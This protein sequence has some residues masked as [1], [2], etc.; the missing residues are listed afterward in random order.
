MLR[1][2]T[3]R[4]LFSLARASLL[5]LVLLLTQQLGMLHVLSHGQAHGSAATTQHAQPNDHAGHAAD[6][7]CQLCLVL[8]ALGA[9]ALPALWR[10]LTPRLRAVAPVRPPLLRVCVAAAAPYQARGPPR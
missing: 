7:L 4:R 6:A 2:V 5:A 1:A 3:H 8:A 9:A 10:W